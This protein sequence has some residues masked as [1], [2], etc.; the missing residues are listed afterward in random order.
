MN[1]DREH[2]K[3]AKRNPPNTHNRM[4]PETKEAIQEIKK[5]VDK[6]FDELKNEHLRPIYE[7][8]K[9]ISDKHEKDMGIIESK[10]ESKVSF[11]IF[12]W[13]LSILM[14]IVIGSQGA[15]WSEAKKANNTANETGSNVRLINFRLDQFEAINN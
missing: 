3:W 4:S 11:K 8:M 5:E 7:Q 12:T 13:V 6:K 14:A 15:I 1:P 10:V 2:A 9:E